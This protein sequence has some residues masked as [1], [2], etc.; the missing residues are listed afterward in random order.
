MA[1]AK[2]SLVEPYAVKLN[3]GFSAQELQQN[4]QARPGKTRDPEGSLP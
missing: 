1:E 4:L 2:I 3:A